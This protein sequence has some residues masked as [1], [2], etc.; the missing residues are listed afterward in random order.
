MKFLINRNSYVE[1]SFGPQKYLQRTV[2]HIH[3]YNQ[4]ALKLMQEERSG[5]VMEHI[6]KWIKRAKMNGKKIVD[7]PQRAPDVSKV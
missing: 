2:F 5:H 7:R 6:A 3:S 4:H 1:V